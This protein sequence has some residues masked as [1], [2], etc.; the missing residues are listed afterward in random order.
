MIRTINKPYL[1][2]LGDIQGDPNAKTAFGLRDWCPQDCLAQLRLPGCTVDLGLQEL[3]PGEAAAA[4]AKSMVIAVA[5][6]GGALSPHWVPHLLRALEAGL[7]LVSGL[8]DRLNSIPALSEASARL[9]RALHDVRHPEGA[10]AVATGRKRSGKRLLTVGT[11]CALGKKYTALALA[12]AL[13][14]KD[15]K[16]DFRATGQT[17]ILIAGSGIPLDAIVADFI[18]GAA[19]SISPDN[20]VTHWDIIEGQGSLFHPAYAGVTLA[21]VHGSQPDALVMC[22][23]PTRKHINGYPNY[24]LPDLKTA[25]R[26]YLEAA[27]LTNPNAKFVG[28]SLNTSHLSSA[29]R[30]RELER[31]EDALGLPCFDPLKQGIEAVIAR[32]SEFA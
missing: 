9:G 31:V 15:I 11:D 7:D 29:D 4:G 5:P 3:C 30:A 14:A 28:V 10:F 16:A 21:L 22:H 26:R 1:L 13:Q 12:A 6:I 2:F 23:D 20:D 27:Y 19:E 8:H 32:L 17:G 25:V 18:A 24:P